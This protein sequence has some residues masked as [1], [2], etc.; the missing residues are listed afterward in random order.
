MTLQSMEGGDDR[1]DQ[2]EAFDE[3]ADIKLTGL[4]RVDSGR[5]MI[6]SFRLFPGLL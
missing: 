2:T 5:K 1:C 4:T 3:L 6:F